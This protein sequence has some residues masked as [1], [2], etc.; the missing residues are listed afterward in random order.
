MIW[1]RVQDEFDRQVVALKT[2]ASNA[3]ARSASRTAGKWVREHKWLSLGVSAAALVAV[4]FLITR[5]T[6]AQQA[7]SPEAALPIVAT[8]T[9]KE[10]RIAPQVALA[11]SVVSQNDAQLASDVEGRVASVA[12]VGTIVKAGDVVARLDSSVAGMQLTSDKANAAKLDAQL[13]FDRAQAE[14]MDSLFSQNAI[15][16]ATRDQAMS[17]RDADVGALAAARAAVAKSQYNVDHD[18][19]RAPFAGRVVQRLINPGEYATMGKPIVRLVDIGTLEVSAQAPIQYSQYIH[20]GQA[21]TS[22]IEDKPVPGKVR[23]IVPVGDQ[24]S[25]TVEVR[26]TLAAGSAFVGDSARVSIPTA[27]PRN[28]IAVPRD[29]LLLREEGTYLFKLDKNNTALRVAV[30]TGSDDGDLIEVR[31]PV[32][33]GDRIVIRGGEHLEAGQKVRIKA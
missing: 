33:A 17:A 27:E 30:E 24:L 5:S 22:T 8:E 14:R 26:I 2:V 7:A 16:K 13:R 11:G 29:A 28:A 3:D 1:A 20:E 25:R 6:S 19:I 31:G 21:L 12:E 32:A 4:A 15:A 9:A 18:E 10:K 23:A